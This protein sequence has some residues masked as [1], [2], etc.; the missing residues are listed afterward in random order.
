MIQNFHFH[1][2][3][4]K[5]GVPRLLPGKN[6]MFCTVLSCFSKPHNRQGNPLIKRIIVKDMFWPSFQRE[7]LANN[8]KSTYYENLH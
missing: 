4:G 2:T 5:V 8:L 1:S 6:A 7:N 3:Y